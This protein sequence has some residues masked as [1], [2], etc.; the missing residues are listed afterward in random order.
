MANS[1]APFDLTTLRRACAPVIAWY[2]RFLAGQRPDVGE[3]DDALVALRRLPS[4]GGR[5]G[6]AVAT[7]VTG[8]GQ[9]STQEVLVAFEHLRSTSA[10]RMPATEPPSPPRRARGERRRAGQPRLPG[11][12]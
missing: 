9:A 5:L 6:R 11:L 8:G 3:L 10:L 2:E 1:P 4:M 7:I 12:G